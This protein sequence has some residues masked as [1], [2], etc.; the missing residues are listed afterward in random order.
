MEPIY[1][2]L[3]KQKILMAV[4][5]VLLILFFILLM[6]Y[7]GYFKKE[8]TISQPPPP[9][10]FLKKITIDFS[11]L[12]HPIFRELQPLEKIELPPAE[13]VGREN[14]FLPP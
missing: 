8:K 4:F 3:Q 5:I 14:P 10:V 12:E 6:H 9:S 7:F 2:K 13:D 1:K 11:I